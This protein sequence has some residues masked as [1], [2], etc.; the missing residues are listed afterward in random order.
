MSKLLIQ[1]HHRPCIVKLSTVVGSTEQ[2]HLRHLPQKRTGSVLHNAWLVEPSLCKFEQKSTTTTAYIT[3]HYLSLTFRRTGF[4]VAYGCI[5]SPWWLVQGP[6]DPWIRANWR[7]PKNSYL[8]RSFLMHLDPKWSR[9]IMELQCISSWTIH[10]GGNK[11][12]GS[13]HLQ[14]PDALGKPNP[15]CNAW[16]KLP[17]RR[18]WWLNQLLC[19][20]HGDGTSKRSVLHVLLCSLSRLKS[21]IWNSLEYLG[22]TST[23]TCTKTAAVPKT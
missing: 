7:F 15:G 3:I 17:P 1:G 5:W 9:Q 6:C 13:A 10:S 8:A 11:R 19:S 21:W 12:A 23:V 18:S 20:G 4:K 2:C 16:G 22:T 14:P